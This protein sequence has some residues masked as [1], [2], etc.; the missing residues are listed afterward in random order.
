[1]ASGLALLATFADL[2]GAGAGVGAGAV[3]AVTEETDIE[4]DSNNAFWEGSFDEEPV[5]GANESLVWI[6]EGGTVTSTA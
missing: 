3:V 6:D 2:A 1:M 4:L 5:T